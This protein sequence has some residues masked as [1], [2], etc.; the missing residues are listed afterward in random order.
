MFRTTVLERGR[1]PHPEHADEVFVSAATA[2]NAGIDI[3]DEVEFRA[4]DASQTTALLEDPWTPPAGQDIKVRV[5]GVAHDV[6]DAQQLQT[7]KLLFG[8][9][10]F[11]EQLRTRRRQPDG[12]L[13]ER[14]SRIRERLPTRHYALYSL[15]LPDGGVFTGS[16]AN[17]QAES[18]DHAAGA[19]VA[20]LV[21]FRGRRRCGRRG[22]D[23]AGHP[24]PSGAGRRTALSASSRSALAASTAPRRSSLPSPRLLCSHSASRSRLPWRRHLHSHSVQSAISNR[25]QG[26]RWMR[27]R[28]S[29]ASSGSWCSSNRGHV[30][31]LGSGTLAPRARRESRRRIGRLEPAG[32]WCRPRSA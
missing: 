30:A 22:G 19:V 2:R 7:T 27:S 25:N 24:Q 32:Q 16:S 21:I 31:W 15:T 18:A 13:A 17:H 14:R 23:R 4:Y 1:L 26:Y 12:G 6:S 3:G 8:T 9:P 11:A 20:G 10:A 29:P 28:S 5:V